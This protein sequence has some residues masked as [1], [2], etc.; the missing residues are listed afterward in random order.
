MLTPKANDRTRTT[1]GNRLLHREQSGVPGGGPNN[2]SNGS[3]S[4]GPGI[5]QEVEDGSVDR[6]PARRDAVALHVVSGTVSVRRPTQRPTERS[7]QRPRVLV[8]LFGDYTYDGRLRRLVSV[9]A[10]LAHVQ[11]LDAASGPVTDESPLCRRTRLQLAPG[12][13]RGRRHLAFW[14]AGWRMARQ[15]RP[16]LVV[17]EGFYAC[18]AG[19]LAAAGSGAHLLYDADELII[20]E[21]GGGQDGQIGQ[22]LG[23]RCRYWMERLGIGRADLVLAANGFRAEVMQRH[24]RLPRRPLLFRNIPP[25][26]PAVPDPV[27]GP[28]LP[29][30]TPGEVRL[31]YQGDLNLRRG[32]GRFI[33]ALQHLPARYALVLAG[34]GPDA[35]RIGKLIADLGLENRVRCLGRVANEHLHLL[36]RQCHIGIVTYPYSGLNNIH[37]ASNKVFEY[38]QCGLP[39]LSTDQPPLR[40]M[41]DTYGIGELVGRQADG[42]ELAQCVMG[43]ARKLPRYRQQLAAFLEAHRW[44]DEAARL[45]LALRPLLELPGDERSGSVG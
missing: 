5:A 12:W 10:D 29:T 24:Y 14:R 25:L 9:L 13:S 1:D 42:R 16:T 21:P 27:S 35:G 4:S 31:L 39:V 6:N 2:G 34:D 19:R 43:L 45:R 36:T 26:P 20:P 22:A 17:A 40:A 30:V 28:G 23:G 32:I 37:C 38:T 8:L 44:E 7:T 33:Q 41:V 3:E 15:S 18:L 11:V